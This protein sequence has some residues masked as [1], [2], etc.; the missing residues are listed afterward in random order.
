MLRFLVD[1]NF[2]N[3]IL[4]GLLRTMP[5][6]DIVRV[7]ETPVSGM[8]DEAVL[9]WAAKENRV[10]LTHDRRTMPRFAYD[11]LRRGLKLS[12]V[13][14]VSRKLA[15][16]QAIDDLALLADASL[17]NEWEGQVLDLLLR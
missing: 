5:T 12:G 2:N 17:D 8:S 1:E 9:E 11:R 6:L 7:Q 10:L 13:V 4:R 16:R 3:D 15:I 14:I